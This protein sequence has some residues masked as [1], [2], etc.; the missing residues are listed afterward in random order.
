MNDSKEGR[1]FK[2]IE[3]WDN[4]AASMARRRFE[5]TGERTNPYRSLPERESYT[6][7]ETREYTDGSKH[8]FKREVSRWG[9]SYSLGDWKEL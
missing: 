4:S 5:K 6:Y 3:R 2:V 7:I 1:E 9:G 8:S